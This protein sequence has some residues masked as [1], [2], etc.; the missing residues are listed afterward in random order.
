MRAVRS[1]A[2]RSVAGNPHRYTDGWV[3]RLLASVAVPA[4][5]AA[6]GGNSPIAPASS[7]TAAPAATPLRFAVKGVGAANAGIKGT[8]EVTPGPWPAGI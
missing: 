5:L 4:A 6:C 2:R 3:S 8:A 7:P 1:T